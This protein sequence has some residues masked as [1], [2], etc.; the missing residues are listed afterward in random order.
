MRLSDFPRRIALVVFM[1]TGLLGRS[2]A[3]SRLSLGEFEALYAEPLAPPQTP[4]RVFH[5]GHSLVGRDMPAMLAQLAPEGHRYES[6]IGWGTTLK[7]H[8]DPQG[9]IA[10]FQENDPNRHRA[11]HEALAS[12][13]YD[14]FVMTEM[15]E[16]RDAIRYF[17][18]PDYAR[19]WAMAARAGNERIRVYLYETWHALSDPDGWLMRL[20]T[21]LHRQWEGEIL[22]RALVAADT[23]AAI[24]II[25]AGQV[26]AKVVREIEAGRISGL[27]SRK[28]L[29]SDDIHVNDAGAYL[30]ALTHYAV[31]YQRDPTGLAYQLNRHDGTP[32]EALPPEAA[33]RMQ[34]IV[35]EVVSAMPRTGIAR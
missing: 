24:Y 6:Q 29:F 4:L 9:T 3:A 7:A 17:D 27:T 35:W 21:D 28:Q 31:L 8:W 33:R 15:V 16:I 5:L 10:G 18:S 26:M 25:P 2:D 1:A 20:D 14:A 19:R 30:V 12:G 11:P 13:E 32:A 22:R 34:E 23:D